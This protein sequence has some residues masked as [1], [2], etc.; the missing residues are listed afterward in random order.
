MVKT[1]QGYTALD[2][3]DVNLLKTLVESADSLSTSVVSGRTQGTMKLALDVARALD[4]IKRKQML[5]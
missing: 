3:N 5:P 2:E 4:S 1:V